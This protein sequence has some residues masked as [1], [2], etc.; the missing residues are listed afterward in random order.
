VSIA[1]NR[2]FIPAGMT[3]IQRHLRAIVS[4]LQ[5]ANAQ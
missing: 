3:S 1:F 5:T 2:A 4:P